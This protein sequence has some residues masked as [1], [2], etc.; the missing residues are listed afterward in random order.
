[1]GLGNSQIMQH[2]FFSSDNQYTV[3]HDFPS[4]PFC[5]WKMTHVMHQV[6]RQWEYDTKNRF[7]C[8]SKKH[9]GALQRE[10]RFRFVASNQ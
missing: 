8:D 1:M 10:L 6:M 4:P 5:P 3:Q 9:L 7:A 2:N